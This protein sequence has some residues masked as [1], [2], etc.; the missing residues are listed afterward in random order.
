MTLLS[1]VYCID[2]QMSSKH[3]E[4]NVYGL[5]LDSLIHCILI[6]CLILGEVEEELEVSI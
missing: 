1:I 5:M 6:G 3:H 4:K 2:I